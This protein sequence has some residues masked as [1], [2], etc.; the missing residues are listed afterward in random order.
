M[1]ALKVSRLL[2]PKGLYTN[3]RC[4]LATVAKTIQTHMMPLPKSIYIFYTFPESELYIFHMFKPMMC[5]CVIV[6]SHF[7]LHWMEVATLK[8]G[9]ARGQWPLLLTNFPHWCHVRKIE[10][11]HRPSSFAVILLPLARKHVEHESAGQTERAL[12][13][14]ELI[15]IKCHTNIKSSHVKLQKWKGCPRNW[16][17]L[18]AH[19]RYVGSGWKS[20]L[21]TLHQK[22]KKRGTPM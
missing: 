19:R 4:W 10:E 22:S 7:W 5:L 13:L 3:W 20:T 2:A 1:C 6:L 21:Q 15:A 8:L 17:R 12:G 11:C 18:R 14:L 9:W 16:A